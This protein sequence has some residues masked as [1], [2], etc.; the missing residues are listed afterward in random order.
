MKH[1]RPATLEEV[2]R[3]KDNSDILPGRTQILEMDK[4]LAVLRFP[5]EINPVHWA[6]DATDKHRARFI[7]SLEERL[8]GM[9]IDRYYS[10]IDATDTKWKAVLEGW[11]FQQ[12][13]PMPEFRMLRIIS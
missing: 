5:A 1:I 9:G 11:G 12:V 3:I 6:P 2:E 7:Y 13:S 8:L 4:T 10:Q